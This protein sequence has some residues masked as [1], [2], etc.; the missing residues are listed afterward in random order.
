MQDY[1]I[2]RPTLNL[3]DFKA[4]WFDD[5]L[6]WQIAFCYQVWNLS[7]QD[8]SFMFKRMQCI[9]ETIQQFYKGNATIKMGVVN[10]E[11]YPI[12]ICLPFDFSDPGHTS[13]WLKGQI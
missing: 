8:S 12:G 10:K 13:Q 9:S 3:R 7:N 2:T 11:P 4:R 5:D 6:A 1:E